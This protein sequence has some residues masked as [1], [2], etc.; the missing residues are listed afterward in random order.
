MESD[1]PEVSGV[2]IIYVSPE[3]EP[4]MIK[5][6]MDKWIDENVHI[7]SDPG[8]IVIF[9][10]YKMEYSLT[11]IENVDH[12]DLLGYMDRTKWATLSD[13]DDLRSFAFQLENNHANL[14]VKVRLGLSVKEYEDVD[15]DFNFVRAYF[16]KNQ[17][18]HDMIVKM[19]LDESL[20]SNEKESDAFEDLDSELFGEK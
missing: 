5:E 20:K 10:P 19:N 16:D 11:K 1:L 7:T 14:K 18:V 17:E 6:Q 13:A 4:E 15:E 3:L 12:L 8:Q 9:S 2:N